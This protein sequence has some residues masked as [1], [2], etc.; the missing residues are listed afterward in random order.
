MK[1]KIR[2]KYLSKGFLLLFLL[3]IFIL[4]LNSPLL[5][6]S[7]VSVSGNNTLSKEQI[8]EIA[9]LKEPV[10]IF[11]VRTDYLQHRLENDLRVEKAIVRRI[12]PNELSIEIKER[13]PLATLRCSYG[14]LD[15]T[16]DGTVINSYKN[17]KAMKYPLLTGTVLGDIYT[18]DKVDDET[19]RRAAA[20]LAALDAASLG[21]ISEINLSAS[22]NIIAYITGGVKIRLGNLS[23]AQQQAKRTAVFLKDLKSIRYPVD[24]VDLGYTSPV[25]KFKS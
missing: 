9:G 14:Y 18:G 23:E 20:Y 11:A 15:I 12:F 6:F 8:C 25:L 3:G 7:S 17:I 16:A 22:Q 4:L 21:Q 2:R 5:A 13:V 1:R 24:Y 19:V 10:N